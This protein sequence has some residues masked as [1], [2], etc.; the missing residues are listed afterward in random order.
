MPKTKNMSVK[1]EIYSYYRKGGSENDDVLYT[2]QPQPPEAR[3]YAGRLSQFRGF[4]PAFLR[5]DKKIRL[6]Y[7]HTGGRTMHIR[8]YFNDPQGGR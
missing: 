1:L 3:R 8:L 4:Y 7:L 6:N 2:Y 5:P